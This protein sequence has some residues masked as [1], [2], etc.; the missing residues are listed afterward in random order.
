MGPMQ[1]KGS[2]KRMQSSREKRIKA[3]DEDAKTMLLLMLCL[4]LK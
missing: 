2:R 3:S 4:N 1:G